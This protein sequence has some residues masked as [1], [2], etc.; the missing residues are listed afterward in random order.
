M[1]PTKEEVI[2]RL[3]EIIHDIK[4]G[5][6]TLETAELIDWQHYTRAQLLDLL[7]LLGLYVY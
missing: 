2:A 5:A 3:E 6:R 7:S 1:E 4:S